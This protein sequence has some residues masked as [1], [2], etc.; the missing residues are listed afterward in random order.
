[1]VVDVSM[2]DRDPLLA[3]GID[4][5]FIVAQ[6]KDYDEI[7]ELDHELATLQAMTDYQLLHVYRYTNRVL[8]REMISMIVNL[9]CAEK[10]TVARAVTSA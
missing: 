4:P 1:M 2:P 5:W 10:I 3:Y 6:G 8:N 9:R 7:T